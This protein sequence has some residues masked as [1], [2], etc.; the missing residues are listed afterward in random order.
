MPPAPAHLPDERVGAV[1]KWIA[2]GAEDTQFYRDEVF[3]IFGDPNLIDGYMCKRAKLASGCIPC[4]VCHNEDSLYSPDLTRPFDP[5]LGIVGVKAKFRSDL[6]LVEPGDPDGSFL[7]QKL[8]A[9]VASSDV[10][11]P[12][13]YGYPHLSSPEVELLRQWIVDGAP[14]N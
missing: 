13:P 12:M 10:G 7:V 4:I 9:T 6:Q 14:N 8:E 11:S 5:V 2:D 3:P 1:R